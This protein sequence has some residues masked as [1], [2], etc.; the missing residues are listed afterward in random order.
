M[1]DQNAQNPQSVPSV[2]VAESAEERE[3]YA[4]GK[5][6]TEKQC[7]GCVGHHYAHWVYGFDLGALQMQKD[8]QVDRRLQTEAIKKSDQLPVVEGV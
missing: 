7:E 6:V 3:V 2:T 8:D 4:I 5:P 1:L